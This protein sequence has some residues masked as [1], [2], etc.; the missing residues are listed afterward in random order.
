MKALLI[1]FPFL[2]TSTH[3]LNIS[4]TTSQQRE[5]ERKSSVFWFRNTFCRSD[6]SDLIETIST[7]SPEECQTKCKENDNCLFF[8][9]HRTRGHGKCYL[10]DQRSNQKKCP[11]VAGSFSSPDEEEMTCGCQDGQDVGPFPYD[12]HSEDGVSFICHNW[13]PDKYTQAGGWTISTSDRYNLFCND[14]S[15]PVVS[16]YC[17][18]TSWKGN[19]DLGFWCY[20]KPQGGRC[21]NKADT[22][23]VAPPISGLSNRMVLCDDPNQNTCEQD[24]EKLCPLEYHLCSHLE[25]KNLNNKWDATKRVLALGEIYC[26]KYGGAGSFTVNNAYLNADPTM[27]CYHGSSRPQCTASYGCDQRQA[28]ALCCSPN[29]NC[30]NGVVNAPLEECDDG[31]SNNDDDCL[32]S[33]TWRF[34]GKHGHTEHC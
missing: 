16:V 22:V 32:N 23:S 27:N 12:P 24:F 34:P 21:L 2:I 14:E 33:C 28:S 10:L 19:L 26:R 11:S 7:D 29:P 25:F 18:E 31:N 8:T 6:D 30:G 3:G 5:V 1:V 17:D 13:S 20:K 15:K 9:F 4:N